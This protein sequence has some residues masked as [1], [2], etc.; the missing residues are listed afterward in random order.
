M[1]FELDIIESQLFPTI[2]TLWHH[3]SLLYAFTTRQ[4]VVPKLTSG[5]DLM[6][7]G[8][9]LEGPATLY[10]FGKL[11]KKAPVYVN[12]EE[13]KAAV[14]VGVT[15]HNSEDLYMCAGRGKCVEILHVI[16]DMLCQLGKPPIRPNL[17]P[18]ITKEKKEP[19]AESKLPDVVS[20]TEGT[21]QEHKSLSDTVGA[22]DVNDYLL[23]S[24]AVYDTEAGSIDPAEDATQNLQ[25]EESAPALDPVQEMDALLEYCF[26]KACKTTIKKGDLPMLSSNFFK[27]H[28]MAV[29][30][31]GQS[32]DVKKSSFK[33]L[34]VFLASMKAKGVIDTSVLKGVESLIFIKADHPLIKQLVV[35]EETPRPEPAVSN[36]PI[37]SECYRVTADV[38]PVL[39]KFGHEKGDVLT[40]AEVRKFFTEYVKKENLQDGKILNLNP[41]LAGILRTKEHQITLTMEDGINK[42]IGRM[43]HTHAITVGGTKLLHSGRLEPI[44]ITVATRSGNKKVTLINNLETFGI[45]LEEFSKECQ[46]IGA[47][48]TIT[49]VPGKKTP[50]VLVQGNQVL[51]VYKLLTGKYQIN[52]NYIRGLEYAPKQ[53]K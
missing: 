19:S 21:V 33:K 30:P 18:P 51:Y 35:T 20:E 11:E 37:V 38:L 2:F 10:S 29:C 53:R 47:S 6:L 39:S 48:A 1:F 42:F 15:A 50:S 14:A 46:G 3:P 4:A 44:D 34:S 41:Q 5:A 17:G 12:T 43:T 49:D 27:N 52:K 9:V 26:L 8:L 23:E 36:A 13:N 32:I 40:R 28:L 45:K 25:A 24:K 31:Q 22:L 16:G 7:P